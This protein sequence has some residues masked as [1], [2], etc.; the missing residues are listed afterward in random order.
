MA[1][2]REQ[3]LVW[4]GRLHVGDEPG[5]FGDAAYCGL[6]C[7]FPLTLRRFDGGNENPVLVLHTA[8]VKIYSG[9]KGHELSVILYEPVSGSQQPPVWKERSIGSARI[10]GDKTEVTLTLPSPPAA[11]TYVSVRI[12]AATDAA[13][14]LYDEFVVHGLA[15]KPGKHG[16]HAQLGFDYHS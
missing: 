2:G 16:Y 14:G 1:L 3:E 13:P 10:T 7:E 5:T 9:Y 8:H 12:R 15:L 11:V 4:E 6:A